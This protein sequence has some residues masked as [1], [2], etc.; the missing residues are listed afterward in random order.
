MMKVIRIHRMVTVVES[1]GLLMNDRLMLSFVKSCL[2]W[3]GNLEGREGMRSDTNL[4]GV[5]DMEKRRKQ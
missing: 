4:I 1:H 5:Q 2:T 3:V